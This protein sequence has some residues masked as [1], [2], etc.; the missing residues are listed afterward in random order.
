MACADRRKRSALA[1]L[2]QVVH[3]LENPPP[4]FINEGDEIT[5]DQPTLV[6]SQAAMLRTM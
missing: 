6:F 2:I 3:L 4:Q 1:G 5:A